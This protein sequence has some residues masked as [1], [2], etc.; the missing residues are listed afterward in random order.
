MC[1]LQD[2]PQGDQ[3]FMCQNLVAT[4]LIIF[5]E[6]T[7]FA[8]YL[9]DFGTRNEVSSRTK[10]RV[11]GIHV[12][13]FSR[14][15]ETHLHVFRK[16]DRSCRLVVTINS[17]PAHYKDIVRRTLIVSWIIFSTFVVETGPSDAWLV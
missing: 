16:R 8:K 3:L 9:A 10:D 4:T 2:H 12:I 7:H 14:V 1:P 15:R 6:H 17:S 11:R 13:A 5:D